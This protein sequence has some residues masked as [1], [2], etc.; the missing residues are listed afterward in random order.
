M[1]SLPPS[2]RY[3]T[4]IDISKLRLNKKNY[5]NKFG[6]VYN[7]IDYEGI[8]DLE[9]QLPMYLPCTTGVKRWENEN[10]P[11]SFSCMLQFPCID[12]KHYHQNKTAR[13]LDEEDR[14]LI[15]DRGTTELRPRTEREVEL[16]LKTFE[17]F[18]AIDAR[19]AKEAGVE[20]DNLRMYNWSSLI[21]IRNKTRENDE[22]IYDEFHAPSLKLNVERD[23]KG[24][25]LGECSL[26]C[27]TIN[28]DG[29]QEIV[30]YTAVQPFSEVCPVFS[31]TRTFKKKKT[32]PLQCGVQITMSRLNFL[33]AMAPKRRVEDADEMHA[34]MQSFLPMMDQTPTAAT[35]SVSI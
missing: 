30:P 10:G 16:E 33:A 15:C 3:I 28:D 2:L 27:R 8:R 32:N 24:E 6:L 7:Y 1:T 13:L 31:L 4:D 5:E 22:I 18:C 19:L 25:N 14:P 9:L 26:I 23:Y 29:E 20:P 35:A 21:Q 12:A 17:A 34:R 11:P